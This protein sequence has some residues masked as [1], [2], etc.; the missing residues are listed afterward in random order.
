MLKKL[1]MK[2]IFLLL[3]FALSACGEKEEQ[4]SSALTAA[5]KSSIA[6]NSAKPKNQQPAIPQEVTNFRE[7]L[8]SV[9]N[10]TPSVKDT[11]LLQIPGGIEDCREAAAEDL[12]TITELKLYNSPK[13]KT[14]DF[15]GL[16]NLKVLIIWRSEMQKIPKNLFAG[17]IN[18]EELD[19]SGNNLNTL[20]KED[21]HHLISLK[22]LDLSS[23]LADRQHKVTKL[24]AGIFKNLQLLEDLN[25]WGQPLKSLPPGVF[26][27]LTSLKS[28]SLWGNELSTADKAR[29]RQK[30]PNVELTL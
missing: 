25:F 6:G 3:V 1:I 10:R 17:L 8:I 19:L 7:D 11:I 2:Y 20:N 18:L 4:P 15:S 21:F 5:P 12:Q 26:D 9:C 16:T 23:H 27:P 14:G 22:K 28:L 29:L 24:P 13:C 30:M